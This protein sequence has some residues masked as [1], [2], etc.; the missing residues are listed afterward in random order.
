MPDDRTLPGH[1]VRPQALARI[2]HQV[3]DLN[4]WRSI[5]P[6]A[7]TVAVPAEGRDTHAKKLGSLR[8]VKQLSLFYRQGLLLLGSPT[9][10]MPALIQEL[11]NT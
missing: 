11:C 6:S 10:V 2:A 7:N 1:D 8:L 9:F 3:S 5:I 4:Y